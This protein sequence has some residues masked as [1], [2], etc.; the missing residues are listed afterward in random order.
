[1]VTFGFFKIF[2]ISFSDVIQQ[3]LS[4]F[5]ANPRFFWPITYIV[6]EWETRLN[7]VE[8]L[9]VVPSIECGKPGNRNLK[10]FIRTIAAWRSEPVVSCHGRQR[11]RLIFPPYSPIQHYRSA[12]MVCAGIQHCSARGSM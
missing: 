7:D 4:T 11:N 8:R 9:F 3:V 1:M 2:S 12:L 6:A 5:R 10:R